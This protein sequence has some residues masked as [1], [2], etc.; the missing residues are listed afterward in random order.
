MSSL[1][2]GW[3]EVVKR[4]APKSRR[5]RVQLRD[6]EGAL[7][8]Q[9]GELKAITDYFK[10]IYG[11]DP[12][13]NS[14]CG[15]M[16]RFTLDEVLEAL[17][18]LQPSKALP[19]QSAPAV[20]W[21]VCAAEVAPGIHRALEASLQ[22]VAPCLP[23]RWHDI[24]VCLIPKVSEVRMPKQLRPICLLPPGSKIVATMLADKL[25]DH[26]ALYMQAIPQFA[27][28]PKRSANDALLRVCSHL[29]LV[30]DLASN[31]NPSLHAKHAGAKTQS[32]RGGVALSLDVNKAFDALPRSYLHQ[33]MRRACIPEADINLILHIHDAA[34]MVYQ[35][36]LS[37]SLEKTVALMCLRGGAAQS[38]LAKVCRKDGEGAQI[39]YQNFEL[40]NLQHRMNVAWG[41][42][43]RLHSILRSRALKLRTK[44]RLWRRALITTMV[45]KQLRIILK[46]PAHIR[47]TTAVQV[48]TACRI[49]DPWCLLQADLANRIAHSYE[50]VPSSHDGENKQNR[51]L[52]H[53]V[54]SVHHFREICCPVCGIEFIS[55]YA[56]KSHVTKEHLRA[57]PD[58]DM[59]P[60]QDLILDM[61]SDV[62]KRTPVLTALPGPLLETDAHTQFVY[63]HALGGMATCVHCRR[64]CKSWHDLTVHITSR[65]CRALFPDGLVMQVP[66]QNPNPIPTAFDPECQKKFRKMTLSPEEN[67]KKELEDATMELGLLASNLRQFQGTEGGL[68]GALMG[69]TGSGLDGD[70]RQA[71]WQKDQSKGQNGKG[72][73]VNGRQKRPFQNNQQGGGTGTSSNGLVLSPDTIQMLIK[74]LLRHEDQLA[75]FRLSTAW[76]F[77]LSAEKPVEIIETLFL[78]ATQWK[79][80]KLND[81]SSLTNPMRVILFQAT[82]KMLHTRTENIRTKEEAKQQAIEMGLYDESKGFPYQ[83]WNAKDKKAQIDESKDP[84]PL[85]KVLELTAEL[86]KLAVGNGVVT[87]YHCTRPLTEDMQGKMTTWLMEV[88]L[89]DSRC[90][91]IWEILAVL[92][93][94]A[95]LK[96]IGGA[97]REERLQRTPLAQLL[98]QQLKR[99]SVDN[100]F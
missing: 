72:W 46:S 100:S 51:A 61:Y 18:K 33:S 66:V 1:F 49:D 98:A 29:N 30:R 12:P 42:F 99:Q 9:E 73:G 27:Y 4:L 94:N 56:M 55:L 90:N 93:G 79:N 64:K 83:T 57:L 84:L 87:R 2:T 40:S 85:D 39:G 58:E 86:M 7:M 54:N 78:T 67:A 71:K 28:L 96:L 48:R 89:R 34:R 47:R 6:G 17:H 11:P 81:P 13:A 50:Q 75:T 15:P 3:R 19:P 36:G 14:P 5:L 70:Q 8:S 52:L 59:D 68:I 44:I 31:A 91:R 23:A 60:L 22:R 69:S 62:T 88:G 45:N 53:P 41:T 26:I 32:L 10:G 82:W 97:I 37:L 95:S 65:S 74:L 21:R 63:M 16:S 80:Q 25:R 76:V 35:A 38:Q 43:W 20:L 77:F 92:K 24:T